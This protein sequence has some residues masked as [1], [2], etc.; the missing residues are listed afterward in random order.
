[1]CTDW[2]LFFGIQ[3]KLDTNPPPEIVT[4]ACARQTAFLLIAATGIPI[5]FVF[6]FLGASSNRL[7]LLLTNSKVLGEF[8]F[9]GFRGVLHRLEPHVLRSSWWLVSMTSTWAHSL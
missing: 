2:R 1:M 7:Y 5:S 8:S 4:L 6:K 9:C 3:L